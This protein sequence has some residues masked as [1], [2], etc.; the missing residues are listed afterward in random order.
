MAAGLEVEAEAAGIGSDLD[1]LL[2]LEA[3]MECEAENM[4]DLGRYLAEK[5]SLEEYEQDFYAFYRDCVEEEEAL[6]WELEDKRERKRERDSRIETEL[7]S[8]IEDSVYEVENAKRALVH[9]R[10]R[11]D[12]ELISITYKMLLKATQDLEN[13]GDPGCAKLLYTSYNLMQEG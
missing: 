4:S 2:G 6:L 9:A 7:R 11:K 5:E 3:Q 10:E 8:I 1:K 13:L 12:E